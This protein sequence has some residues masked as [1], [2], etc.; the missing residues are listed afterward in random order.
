MAV[1]DLVLCS[2]QH[3]FACTGSVWVLAL[4]SSHRTRSHEESVLCLSEW[5]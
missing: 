2:Y 4:K 5:W 3:V 1:F